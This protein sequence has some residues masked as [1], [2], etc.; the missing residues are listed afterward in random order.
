MRSKEDQQKA[1]AW[2]KKLAERKVTLTG[3]QLMDIIQDFIQSHEI[4]WDIGDDEVSSAVAYHI[5]S[6]AEYLEYD[7][8]VYGSL[9]P[10]P[11]HTDVKAHVK[12]QIENE[13]VPGKDV[14]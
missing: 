10:T 14:K 7:D 6:K 4:D 11:Y 1:D 5:L 2:I 12:K 3:E 9:A 8:A 13:R